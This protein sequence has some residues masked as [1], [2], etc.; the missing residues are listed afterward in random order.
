MRPLDHWTRRCAACGYMSAGLTPGFGRGVDGLAPVQRVN[1][2][3]TLDEIRR[4]LGS[5]G[6]SLLD[7]GCG[8]GGDSLSARR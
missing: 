2:K 8:A 7:V 6:K 4:H 5:G 1:D 3:A